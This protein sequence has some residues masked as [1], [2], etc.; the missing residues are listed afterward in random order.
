MWAWLSAAGALPAQA[1]MN[2][3]PVNVLLTAQ[4]PETAG[5]QWTAHPASQFVQQT[6]LKADLVVLQS[7]WHF[8]AGQSVA[9]EARLVRAQPGEVDLLA[10]GAAAELRAPFVHS[11]LP[12]QAKTQAI[13]LKDF[14]PQDGRHTQTDGLLVLG[15][16][17]PAGNDRLLLVAVTA[18]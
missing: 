5:V 3:L 1:Q 6:G 2:S 14:R 13:L 8:A 7:T 16:D 18:L 12:R 4:M 11:F 9:A 10:L 17:T 15:T